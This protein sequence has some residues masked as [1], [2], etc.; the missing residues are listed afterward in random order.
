MEIN[1]HNLPNTRLEIF[2][3]YLQT[4]SFLRTL[5]GG[6]FFFFSQ[7]FLEISVPPAELFP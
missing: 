3:R 5:V 7:S 2:R 4:Q 1:H 6:F